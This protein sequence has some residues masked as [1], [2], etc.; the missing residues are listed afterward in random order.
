MQ[1]AVNI[2]LFIISRLRFSPRLELK[3]HEL[4]GLVDAEQ[5]DNQLTLAS[6]V[7]CRYACKAI[8]TFFDDTEPVRILVGHYGC[9]DAS[10][11]RAAR[12]GTAG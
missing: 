2:K 5:S 12:I 6:L 9:R 1:R 11:A 8:Q 7:S 10:T 4:P 3:P